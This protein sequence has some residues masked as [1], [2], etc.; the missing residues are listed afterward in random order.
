MLREAQHLALLQ[1][2]RVEK[3]LQDPQLS[4]SSSISFVLH[5]ASA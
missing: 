5:M 1:L 3:V 2:E 4:M